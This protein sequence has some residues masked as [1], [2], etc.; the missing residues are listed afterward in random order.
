MALEGGRHRALDGRG[1]VGLHQPQHPD[2]FLI[3]LARVLGQLRPR[4]LRELLAHSSRPA[5]PTGRQ[6]SALVARPGAR[7]RVSA[8]CGVVGGTEQLPLSER[9][10]DF[11]GCGGPE[12]VAVV[13]VDQEPAVAVSG[14]DAPSPLRHLLAVDSHHRPAPRPQPDQACLGGDT[15]PLTPARSTRP[16]S[17]ST[18]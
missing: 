6:G 10:I 16:A 11:G 4:P 8:D 7:A 5:G 15:T 18:P 3:G 13:D 14:G 2:P 1:R 17:P 12:P 9:C